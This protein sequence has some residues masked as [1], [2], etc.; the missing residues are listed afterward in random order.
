MYACVYVYLYIYVCMY[1]RLYG[2]L[3]LVYLCV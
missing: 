1:V 3:E 2:F